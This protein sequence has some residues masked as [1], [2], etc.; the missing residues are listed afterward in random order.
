MPRLS[1][2]TRKRVIILRRQGYSLS[3]IRYRLDEEGISVSIR[4]LQRLCVKFDTFHTVENL[5]RAARPRL[6]SCEMLATMNNLLRNDDDLTARRLSN[7]LREEYT[8]LPDVSLST[9]KKLVESL[10]IRNTLGPT[11]SQRQH[12]YISG[13]V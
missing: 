13:G 2:A 9:I 3:E 1:V 12:T 7:K 5:P 6:L 11:N 8:N 4:S 10:V